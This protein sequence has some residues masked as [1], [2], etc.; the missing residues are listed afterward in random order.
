MGK[1]QR[2]VFHSAHLLLSNWCSVVWTGAARLFNSL[3]EKR[4]P[5]HLIHL[6]VNLE[7]VFPF[8]L[9]FY[10]T[11]ANERQWWQWLQYFLFVCEWISY[12]RHCSWWQ[13]NNISPVFCFFF[14]CK[15]KRKSFTCLI[16]E[17][18]KVIIKDLHNCSQLTLKVSWW[19]LWWLLTHSYFLQ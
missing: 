11:S 5:L 14:F 10:H 13:H 6:F 17:E 19:N 7:L 15:A 1:K 3:C 16:A 4:L 18:W 8:V 2:A 12:Y 9:T